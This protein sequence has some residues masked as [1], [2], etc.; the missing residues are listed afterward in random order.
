MP[1]K[2]GRQ[3]SV[4]CFER[5]SPAE[6]LGRGGRLQDPSTTSSGK[7]MR[8][9]RIRAANQRRRK[10]RRRRSCLAAKK[11]LEPAVFPHV[12]PDA[13]M[14]KVFQ[15]TGIYGDNLKLLKSQIRSLG[16]RFIAVS[17]HVNE[18]KH[19]MIREKEHVLK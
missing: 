7:R 16:G 9:K 11:R 18:P 14:D 13:V 3:W 12:V 17:V 5:V 2:A 19:V 1:K 6:V 8:R 10:Q 15:S 4:S